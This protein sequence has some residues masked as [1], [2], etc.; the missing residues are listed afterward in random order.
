[1]Q[2]TPEPPRV[3]GP[4]PAVAKEELSGEN[5]AGLALMRTEL[6]VDD[7]AVDLRPSS[8][9]DTPLLEELGVRPRSETPAVEWI[10][11][12]AGEPVGYLCAAATSSE[13]R[14]YE[15]LLLRAY[16]GRGIRTALVRE[17]LAD[18][19]RLGLPLRTSIT[20]E[21]SPLADIYRAHGLVVKRGDGGELHLA[22]A[23]VVT[24]RPRRPL[25]GKLRR[26]RR[27]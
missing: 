11:S 7:V 9:D 16:E 18:A 26:S 13:L 19:L 15:L 4:D 12:V 24:E 8:E 17:L 20:I 23:P 1:M 14:V 3:H 5:D 21:Q 22:T 25:A 10:V 2:Q 6:V 27:R